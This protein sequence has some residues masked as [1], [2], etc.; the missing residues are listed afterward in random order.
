MY[1]GRQ[2]SRRSYVKTFNGNAPLKSLWRMD[3]VAGEPAIKG[4]AP[5]AALDGNLYLGGSVIHISDARVKTNVADVD[6]TALDRMLRLQPRSYSMPHD[7]QPHYGLVAQEVAEHMPELVHGSDGDGWSVDYVAL[8]PL[9][10]AKI[11]RL[12]LQSKGSS[13][14]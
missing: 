13:T 10:L 2:P 3:D 5:N 6:D 4:N 1:N 8:V 12:E 7:A 11:Q 9:L 14:P